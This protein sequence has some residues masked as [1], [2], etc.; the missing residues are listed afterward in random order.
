MFKSNFKK[1]SNTVSF[2][3]RKNVIV[4]LV[5]LQHEPHSL[6]KFFGIPPITFCVQVSQVEFF[7]RACE[8]VSYSARN[9]TGNKRFTS[10]GTLV[11]EKNPVTSV[12][13]IR[14]TV[15]HRQP[16]AKYLSTTI[17]RPGVKRSRF[18]LRNF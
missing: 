16:V 8:Y 4:R 2:P 12:Q 13:P 7:L 5:L 15:I 11:I 6:D 9:L 18:P 10:A 17:R 14:L 1:L 3:R